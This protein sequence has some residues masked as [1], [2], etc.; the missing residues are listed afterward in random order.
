MEAAHVPRESKHPTPPKCEFHDDAQLI[1]LVKARVQVNQ[2]RPSCYDLLRSVPG[3]L[4]YGQDA[5]RD[6]RNNKR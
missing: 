5:S 3:H 4:E 6:H 2:Q 1:E